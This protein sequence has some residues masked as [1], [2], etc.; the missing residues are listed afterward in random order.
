MKTCSITYYHN[1]KIW[2]ALTHNGYFQIY[3]LDS[4]REIYQADEVD[5]NL[6]M[7]IKIINYPT[8][9]KNPYSKIEL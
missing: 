7:L 2:K 6:A 4:Q 1:R 5:V 9:L 3:L 8:R